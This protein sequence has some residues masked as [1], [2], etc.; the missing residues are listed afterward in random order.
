[1]VDVGETA[2]D[3]EAPTQTGRPLRLSSLRGTPVV[4]Y[5][6]PQADTPGCTV[7]SKSFRDL[8]PELKSHHVEVVGISTDSVDDQNA[9]CQKYNLPFPLVAD[10]TKEVARRYGVLRPSGRANR[11]TFLI[12]KDGTVVEVV[13]N[14]SPEPHLKAARSRFL[15]S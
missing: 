12:D 6:Y 4:L 8:Y 5:F 1:M 3:F 11:V 2:P 9:F 13:A 15:S 14:G 7:E 10:S